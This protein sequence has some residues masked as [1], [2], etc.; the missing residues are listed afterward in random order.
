MARFLWICLGGAL[1][2]G[3]RYL[4]SLGALRLLG[5]AFPW[6][7]LIVNAVG[8]FLISVLM[9]LGLHTTL[10]SPTLRLT[11]TTGIMGGLTTYSTFNYET[12]KYFQEGAWL[13]GMINV[14]TTLVVCMAAGVLGL[15]AVRWSLGR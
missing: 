14:V 2:T 11:L 1:G 3:A 12:L 15:A 13:M 6:G 8:C 4:V 10:L 9:H 7:T 5:P